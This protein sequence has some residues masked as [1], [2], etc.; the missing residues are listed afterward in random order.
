MSKVLLD[1]WEIST[2]LREKLDVDQALLYDPYGNYKEFIDPCWQNFLTGIILWDDVYLNLINKTLTRTVK[3]ETFLNL[4]NQYIKDTDFI[5]FPDTMPSKDIREL[6]NKYCELY[7]TLREET[8]TYNCYDISLHTIRYIIQANILNC[9][10]LPHPQRAE[11]LLGCEV[12]E[13]RFDRTKYIDII[14]KEVIKYINEVNQL[15]DSQLL[16]TSFPVL[17]KFILSNGDSPGE[18]LSFAYELRKNANVIKFRES[19]SDIELQLNN[20]NIQALRNSL[21]A[22]KEICD[23]ITNDMYKKPVS[24]NI[25]LGLSPSI[26]IEFDKNGKTRSK[27]HTT[28][29]YDLASF[30]IT[31]K[32]K[33][34]Y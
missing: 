13:K 16:T 29:L 9:N 28:F 34:K 25:S 27:L 14:D 31:G 24:F 33:N 8:K 30:A 7:Y 23:Y 11:M 22:T 15:Y 1:N 18:Q 12:F 19:I 20:G 3:P 6:E 5:H 17:Y 26:N 32:T 10:Y 2:C 21:K 4:I